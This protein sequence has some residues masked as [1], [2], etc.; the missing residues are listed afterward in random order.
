MRLLVEA[1][2]PTTAYMIARVGLWLQSRLSR[3]GGEE[4]REAWTNLATC[5]PARG[6]RE[7]PRFLARLGCACWT[8]RSVG[9]APGPCPRSARVPRVTPFCGR[10]W[11]RPVAGARSSAQA[12][13][14]GLHEQDS[15]STPYRSARNRTWRMTFWRTRALRVVDARVARPNRGPGSARFTGRLRNE[16]GSKVVIAVR[17]SWWPKTPTFVRSTSGLARV[18]PLS[19][20]S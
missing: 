11:M 10:R 19:T 16:N 4:V 15:A 6:R 1:S 5:L 13:R 2:P 9:A 17:R 3:P 18:A 20:L 8:H 7:E 12:D 14:L